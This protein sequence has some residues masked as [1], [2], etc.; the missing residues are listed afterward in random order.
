MRLVALLVCAALIA[1]VVAV[2]ALAAGAERNGQRYGARSGS[3][4]AGFG[5][6]STLAAWDEAA[7]AA[8][9]GGN[10]AIDRLVRPSSLGTELIV[11]RATV[12]IGMRLNATIAAIPRPPSRAHAIDELLG[13]SRAG[14]PLI[15]QA[16]TA[17]ERRDAALLRRVEKR[18]AT[19]G[20]AFNAAAVRLGART[21]AV[22]PEPGSAPTAP[23]A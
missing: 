23:V 12:K 15:E 14:V 3:G 1:A 18:A 8:C 5:G 10:V 11:L 19:I 21:C 22:N 17:Y 9:N 4:R 13:L 2:T 16:I 20:A 6:A 7:N